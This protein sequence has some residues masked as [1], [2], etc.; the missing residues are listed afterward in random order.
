M[1]PAVI[2][3]SMTFFLLA[4]LV[5]IAWAVAGIQVPLGALAFVSLLA[6][7]AGFF[8]PDVLLSRRAAQRR[9]G[10]SRDQV[11]DKPRWRARSV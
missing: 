1:S 7:A 9:R 4:G 5:A 10:S 6:G 3:L 2:D 8:V 11:C